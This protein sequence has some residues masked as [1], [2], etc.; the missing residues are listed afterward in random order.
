[1]A[2]VYMCAALK[3]LELFYCRSHPSMMNTT[4]TTNNN[5]NNSN[6]S[7]GNGNG[8]SG[9]TSELRPV[10]EMSLWEFLAR[11]LTYPDEQ[12]MGRW[13]LAVSPDPVAM[14]KKD[15]TAAAAS[16]SRLT[17][18]RVLADGRWHSIMQL[19]GA[20]KFWLALNLVM[21]FLPQQAT[22]AWYE[23]EGFR[24]W[25]FMYLSTYSLHIYTT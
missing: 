2:A 3:I 11:F 6:S 7:N 24:F 18:R 5:N 23:L 20:I 8:N 22:R 19:M 12:F 4:T 10:W 16:S 15:G 25:L 13:V 9:A 21:A 1:M 14:L 17:R